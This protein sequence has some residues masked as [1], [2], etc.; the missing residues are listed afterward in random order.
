MSAEIPIL[1]ARVILTLTMPAPAYGG[2]PNSH[3]TN[4]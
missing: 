1:Y 4:N 2:Q 3:L